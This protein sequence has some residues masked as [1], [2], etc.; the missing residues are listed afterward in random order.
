VD[1][2]AQRWIHHQTLGGSAALDP[3]YRYFRPSLRATRS[4]LVFHRIAKS[5]IAASP[6]RLLAMTRWKLARSR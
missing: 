2:G 1:Q 5:E 4:N 3:P 6:F